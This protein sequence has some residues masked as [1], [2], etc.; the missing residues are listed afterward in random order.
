MRLSFFVAVPLLAAACGSDPVETG[1]GG[2]GGEN[3]GATAPGGAGGAG[4]AGPELCK[5]TG[6]GPFWLEEGE[7]VTVTFTCETGALLDGADLTVEGLPA[8]ATYDAASAS[9]TFTPGLDQAS[10]YLW[11]ATLGATGEVGLVKVGVADKFDDPANVP[12]TDPSAYTEEYG[13]PVLFLS[14]APTSETYAPA[15]TVYRGHTYSMQAKLRGAASLNYPKNSFTLE[16]DKADKF[17]EPFEADGFNGRRKVVLISTFDDNSY[18]RQR[19]A[20]DLWDRLDPAHI[21]I[22]TY[23]AVIYVDGVYFGLYTVSDH[24]DG[25]LMEDHGYSQDGNLYKAVNHD[26]N[27]ALTSIQ[28]GGAPKATLHDGYEKREGTP[29]D[30]EPG[31]YAD[32]EELV[33]FVATSDSTTFLSELPQR[34]DQRD[35]QDW[36]VF[37]TYLLADDS[38]GKNS[39]LYHDPQ[40]PNGVFRYAPWDFN[41]SFGQTWQTF[42]EGAS[43]Y[44][45]YAGNNRLFARFLEEPSL[46]APLE[47][48]YS[49]A[50]KGAF[51]ADA[52]NALVDSY[53]ARITPS[54][55]RDE[56]RWE[57]EYRAFPWWSS[58]T[59][60]ND[61]EGEVAYLKAWIEERWQFQSALYP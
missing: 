28:N 30:G 50:L 37:V 23:S 9:V 24:V 59:D 26:A 14:P 44:E 16:F 27:F 11:R 61:F 12:V 21:Q 7:S 39:Y 45:D 13:L 48:R 8:N 3:V 43:A 40:D 57:A 36:F 55:H 49:A 52:V 53:V 54:A 19:L 5:P 6:G 34:I 18:V 51:S 41:H 29:L 46:T 32:L 56:R 1:G 42:R 22:K 35:F 4:G 25:F 17:D 33:N 31:A 20:Y 10:V 60:F 2:S 58:R 47:A 38:A 15:T